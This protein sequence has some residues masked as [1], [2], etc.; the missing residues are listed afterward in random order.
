MAQREQIYRLMLLAE[1]LKRKQKGVTYDE[2]YDYLD[3][4]FRDKGF[5]LKFS[6]K[7]FKR[8]AIEAM[9]AFQLERK[10]SKEEILTLYLN[11]IYFEIY[12]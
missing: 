7:T 4:K 1:L 3:R 12:N 11:E 2:A 10:Y 9:M 6:E 5:D 8:K